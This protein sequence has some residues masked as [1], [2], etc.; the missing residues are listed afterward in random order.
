MLYRQQDQKIA[1]LYCTV[2]HLGEANT[3]GLILFYTDKYAKANFDCFYILYLFDHL[4]RYIN[5]H[6][7]AIIGFYSVCLC[8]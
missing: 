7:T 8:V 3:G 6:K 5:T 4:I 2:L 1:C